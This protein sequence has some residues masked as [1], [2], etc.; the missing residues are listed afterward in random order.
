MYVRVCM[1]AQSKSI[2]WMYLGK[3]DLK[4]AI[5]DLDSQLLSDFAPITG[6]SSADNLPVMTVP[7]QTW[8]R[9]VVHLPGKVVQMWMA[10]L[11][12]KTD[13]ACSETLT[14]KHGLVWHDPEKHTSVEAT[15]IICCTIK[16]QSTPGMRVRRLDRDS[17]AI[18]VI[19]I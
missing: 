13:K 15:W 9:S 10:D 17:K 3:A 6:R 14:N 7:A 2:K 12:E 11:T 1:T 4:N 5:R 19:Y 16:L 8:H 18:A